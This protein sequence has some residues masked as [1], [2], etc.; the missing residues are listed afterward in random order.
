PGRV[1]RGQSRRRARRG[2]GGRA[3]R[4]RA[5]RLPLDRQGGQSAKPLRR[6][7][8][9]QRGPPARDRR[10]VEHAGVGGAPHQRARQPGERRRHLRPPARRWPAGH[11][12][13][14]GDDP[15]LGR[16]PPRHAAGGLRRQPGLRRP[17]HPPPPR[18]PP[19]GAGDRD[20]APGL[21]GVARRDGGAGAADH[22][23]RPAAGRAA[24]RGTDAGRRA[25]RALPLPWGTPGRGRRGGAGRCAGRAGDR[26]D[27]DPGRG[28]R[29][30][31]ARPQG[32]RPGLGARSAV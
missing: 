8:A 1:Y 9:D 20:R 19:G 10:R 4:R 17:L 31:R 3:R 7:E 27:P 2:R 24:P 32:A 12:D 30:R 28:G 11:G 29:H 25:A 18:C 6:D 5:A 14:P 21:D 13:R 26:R 23:D 22:R 16:A 15:L